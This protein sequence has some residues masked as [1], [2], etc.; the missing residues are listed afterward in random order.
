MKYLKAKNKLSK[1]TKS[2]LLLVFVC[3]FV[4]MFVFYLSYVVNPLIIG[5][6]EAKIRSITQQSLSNSILSVI[7]NS[8]NT[9]TN[10]IKYQ[11]DS[12]DNISLITVDTYNVNM[13]AREISLE[14]QSS[15]DS[16]SQAGVDVHLG[17]FFGVPAL[18]SIGPIIKFGLSPIGTVI[19]SFRSEFMTA[20]INQTH[21]KIF[22]NV[23]SSVFVILPTASP[24]IHTSAEV[25]IAECVIVG[26]VPTTYLQSSYLDEML[27]LVPV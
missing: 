16:T 20:G 25:L 27:N 8:N 4:L 18:A 9:Y 1:R 24:E 6:S 21:H 13:L 7:T 3:V 17:A 19:I 22:V 14:A 2:R 10:L 12:D 26:E 23:E 11:Y 15:L 5:A